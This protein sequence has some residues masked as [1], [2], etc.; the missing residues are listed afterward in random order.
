MH[1]RLASLGLAVSLGLVGL[2]TEPGVAAA[3]TKTAPGD[4]ALAEALFRDA[5][6]LMQQNKHAEA[7]PKLEESQRLDPGGGTQ[8]TLAL[9]YEGAG[10]FA[11]AWA[12]F[13][14]ALTIA[15]RDNRPERAK[16]A[17]EKIDAV[18][19]KMA[20]L[21]VVVPADVAALGPEVKRDGSV[22]RPTVWG[23]AIPVD[24]GEHVVEATA[25]GKKKWARKVTAGGAEGLK[26]TLKVAKLE[27]E[28]EGEGEKVDKPAEPGSKPEAPA[29]GWKKPTGITLLVAGAIGVGVGSYFGFSALSKRKDADDRCPAKE[30]PD[31]RAIT[32]V[33]ESKSAATLSTVGIGVGLG[34]AVVGAVL[35]VTSPK[36]APSTAASLAPVRGG[37]SSLRPSFTTDSRGGGSVSLTGS[38]LASRSLALLAACAPFEPEKT[39]RA[40]RPSRAWA[41]AMVPAPCAASER[42]RSPSLLS[43]SRPFRW[44]RCGPSRPARTRRNRR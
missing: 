37:F 16:I 6:T 32:L 30:C 8:L 3:Q 24:P 39:G 38:F 21:T 25:P 35:V 14:E 31:P 41:G 20:Y 15:K 29:G 33:D 11:S 40:V 36:P 44:C 18:S 34:L 7:C 42:S 2:V 22:L 27:D 9:C 26:I 23:T 1:R 17:Q 19:A 12:A 43:S 5:K 4:A 13:S 10:R 28:G